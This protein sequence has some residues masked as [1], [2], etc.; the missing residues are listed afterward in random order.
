MTHRDKIL[1]NLNSL[2]SVPASALQAMRKLQDPNAN[3]GEVVQI[4]NYDPGMTSNILKLANSSYFGCSHAI[5]TLRD[6]IVRLGVKKTFQLVTA[7]VASAAIRT[8]IRGYVMNSD[9]LWDH[10]IAVA[11]AAENLADSLNLEGEKI[12]FTAGLLH[13]L[14]KVV[15][16]KHLI[17]KKVR[18]EFQT[19]VAASSL[20]VSAELELLGI[21]HAEAG[22]LLL[23]EWN[24]PESLVNAVRWHHDPAQS[25][26]PDAA[27]IHIADALCVQNQIGV[28]NLDP[29]LEVRQDI[30]EKMGVTA[31]IKEE[32]I[33][34]TKDS[35]ENIKD[36]FSAK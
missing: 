24:I 3:M 28:E 11:V 1:A 19:A 35:F 12:A 29:K 27:I 15:I 20:L 8:K 13:D 36:V 6:A 22:G 33:L 10:S 9:Q 30:F 5:S 26:A 14:G 17:D 7:A 2:S 34:R 25:E 21:D 16:G 31:A 18:K 4:I 32:V 23:Q